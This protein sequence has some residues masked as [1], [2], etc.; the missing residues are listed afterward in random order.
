LASSGFFFLCSTKENGQKKAKNKT[1]ESNKAKTKQT[2]NKT[3]Q[4][5]NKTNKEQWST[6]TYTERQRLV[7]T[8]P[9]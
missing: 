1:K 7:N 8:N 6:K 2:K 5:K 4:S 9:H 3:K